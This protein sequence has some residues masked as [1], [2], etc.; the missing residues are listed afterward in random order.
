MIPLFIP[1]ISHSRTS[2]RS[3]RLRTDPL[4]FLPFLFLLVTAEPEGM[5]RAREAVFRRARHR[6]RRLGRRVCGE[7]ED[8]LRIDERGGLIVFCLFVS[9][10]SPSN[11]SFL[12]RCGVVAPWGTGLC[13]SLFICSL[14]LCVARGVYCRKKDERIGEDERAS[15]DESEV[16][17]LCS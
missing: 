15:C 3:I 8:R 2:T 12:S 14:E 9:N 17:K 5:V 11:L 7:R 16:C 10:L 13:D 6:A 1:S 4:R